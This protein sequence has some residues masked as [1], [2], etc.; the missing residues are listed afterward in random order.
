MSMWQE[1]F[2]IYQSVQS[3]DATQAQQPPK[4]DK[5]ISKATQTRTLYV[6]AYLDDGSGKTLRSM[7]TADRL[8]ILEAQQQSLEARLA[9]LETNLQEALEDAQ[10]N[11]EE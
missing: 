6:L 7:P 9:E 4:E 11:D 3:E 10:D 1:L 8:T 5:Q 2:D